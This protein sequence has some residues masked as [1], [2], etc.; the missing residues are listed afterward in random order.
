MNYAM[1]VLLEF[2]PSWL[3][4]SREERRGHAGGL[5][6]I[7]GT[8][9]ERVKVRFYDAE[10]LPGSYFT[11]FVLCETNDL[12]AYHFMWEE[13]RDSEPYTAGYFRIKD[14]LMGMEDAFQAYESENLAGKA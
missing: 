11:D 7:I 14:V 12:K 6:D 1:I 8:Y 5:R 9:S 4:L 2:Y 10:A 13:L 3:A